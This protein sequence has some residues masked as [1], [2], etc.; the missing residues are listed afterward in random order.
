M[1]L[2]NV[3][4]HLSELAELISQL[5]YENLSAEQ[6]KVKASLIETYETMR[7]RVIEEYWREIEMKGAYMSEDAGLIGIA[8]QL[9]D[10]LEADGNYLGKTQEAF[11]AF[12]ADLE[13]LR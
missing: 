6:K 7:T 12:M 9:K 13:Q 11:D 4:R 10:Q 2:E 8:Q 5:E 3:R 1:S